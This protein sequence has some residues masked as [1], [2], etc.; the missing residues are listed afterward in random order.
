MCV[1]LL[2]AGLSTLN[3]VDPEVNRAAKIGPIVL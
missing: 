2:A 1:F 3:P